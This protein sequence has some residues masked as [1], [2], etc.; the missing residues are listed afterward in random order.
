MASFA[1]RK[2]K[3]AAPKRLAPVIACHAFNWDRTMCAVCPNS[4]KIQI[5]SGCDNP[6]VSK[7]ATDA[8]AA[9][10][11]AFRRAARAPLRTAAGHW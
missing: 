9:S 4:G 2:K 1:G 6:D 8:S 5:Y 3:A 7:W 10:A 11:R